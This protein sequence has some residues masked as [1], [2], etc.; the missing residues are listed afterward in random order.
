MST[1]ESTATETTE[2]PAAATES[3]G[4]SWGHP[5]AEALDALPD[6]EETT[7]A[8]AEGE[9]TP[10]E[11]AEEKPVAKSK[12]DKAIDFEALFS[13]E[14][15]KTPEGLKAARDAALELGK[16]NNRKHVELS[17]REERLKAKATKFEGELTQ[18][19]ALSGMLTADLQALRTGKPEVALQA[20][21]RMTGSDP[22]KLLEEINLNFAGGGQKQE[23][24]VVK[25]LQSQLAQLRHE[26]QER[27]QRQQ[28]TAQQ[29]F[30][31]RRKQ[32]IYQQAV[33]PGRYPHV[34]E[35]AQ[36]DPRGVVEHIAKYIIEQ[37]AHGPRIDDATAISHIEAQLARF[38]GSNAA[39][40]RGEAGREPSALAKPESGQAPRPPGK[41][42]TPSLATRS[43]G[44]TRVLTP[45]EHLAALHADPDSILRDLGLSI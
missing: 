16:R 17:N 9:A 13:E 1:A 25:E 44:S 14:K 36:E 30:I 37:N 23:T 35:L 6:P 39:A 38:R 10:E 7:E 45:D 42:L 24:Q 29:Q 31:A 34:A 11:P 4:E 21:A 26:L 27:D 2:A 15:L 19:R 18:A 43:G 12:K 22:L 40:P 5:I 33:D 20:L 41:T 28:Q 32:E 8:T 3:S